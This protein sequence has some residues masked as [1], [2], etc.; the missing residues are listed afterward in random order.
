MIAISNYGFLVN[1][2]QAPISELFPLEKTVKS[3]VIHFPEV[4]RKLMWARYRADCR[5]ENQCERRC[6]I[7]REQTHH[8]RI[9]HVRTLKSL[10]R[11]YKPRALTPFKFIVKYHFCSTISLHYHPSQPLCYIIFEMDNGEQNGCKVG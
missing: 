7:A 8:I 10:L 6:Y 9:Y 11:K 5:C 1:M 3:E 4:N 2:E